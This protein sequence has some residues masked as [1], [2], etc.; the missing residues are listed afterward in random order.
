VLIKV[1][2]PA[3]SFFPGFSYPAGIR[4]PLDTLAGVGIRDFVPDNTIQVKS[5]QAVAFGS[6]R[7]WYGRIETGA[8]ASGNDAKSLLT[9][10][11]S[12]VLGNDTYRVP[13][14]DVSTQKVQ[15]FTVTDKKG[16]K[17]ESKG[18]VLSV[19]G[20]KVPNSTLKANVVTA[21]NSA[22][23]AVTALVHYVH[24]LD[25]YRQNGNSMLQSISGGCV[26]VEIAVPV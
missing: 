6:H 5:I 22:R 20:V 1:S 3:A 9:K 26:V 23:G 8:Q 21:S 13:F 11:T 10:G 4:L 17:F 24:T 12:M 14:S 18:I 15:L 19:Q 7:T 2:T 25:K 16:G